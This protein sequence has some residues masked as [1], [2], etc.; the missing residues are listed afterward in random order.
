MSDDPV[1]TPADPR[2]PDVAAALAALTAELAQGGYAPEQTFGYSAEQ[3]ERR[4]V[5]LV[6]ARVD[7]VF[8]GV[9]GVEVQDDGRAEL[10]RFWVDPTRRGTGVADAVLAALVEYARGRG[11]TVLRLETGDRQQAAIRFYARHGFVAVPRFPPYDDSATSVC[12]QRGI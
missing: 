12:L 3:L 6:A 11:V 5:H 9:G 2:A 10:T 8:A 4:G 7:G 1:V